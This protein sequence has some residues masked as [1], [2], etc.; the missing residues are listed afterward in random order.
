MCYTL[1]EFP[2]KEA[3]PVFLSSTLERNIAGNMWDMMLGSSA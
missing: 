2:L 3:D 1:D